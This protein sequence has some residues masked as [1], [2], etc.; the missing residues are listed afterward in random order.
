MSRIILLALLAAI[1]ST[2]ASAD[3]VTVDTVPVGDAGN[4]ADSTAFGAVGYNYR[5]ATTEV[6][7]D[8]YAAF[9]NAKAASDSLGL[10]NTA[11]GS[12]V[13]GGITRSGSDG[14]YAYSVK[15]DM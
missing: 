7:N 3:A 15:A 11:M 4:A 13:R 10:Y 2:C 1:V 6:T 8:K 5:I 14:G 12:H 9:L